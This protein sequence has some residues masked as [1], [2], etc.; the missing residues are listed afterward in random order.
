MGGIGNWKK[1]HLTNRA[2]GLVC[3]FNLI[4][5]N[6]VYSCYTFFHI[7]VFWMTVQFFLY[8]SFLTFFSPC[9]Y[10]LF[11]LCKYHHLKSSFQHTKKMALLFGEV[12]Y[13]VEI[14]LLFIV[15]LPKPLHF[16]I[17]HFLLAL[18]ILCPTTT[19]CPPLSLKLDLK[20]WEH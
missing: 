3:R 8:P 17:M 18:N 10:V 12:S 13:I 4:S 20:P 2:T 11:V 1:I 9:H 7:G 14:V 5:T 19:Y 16:K 15:D 6:I